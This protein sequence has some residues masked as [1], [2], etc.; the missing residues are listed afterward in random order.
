MTTAITWAEIDPD[1]H[2]AEP[3]EGLHAH[4]DAPNGIVMLFG[5]EDETRF[6]LQF[7][8]RQERFYNSQDFPTRAAAAAAL[9][10]LEG[11]DI[12]T[13]PANLDGGTADR[14]LKWATERAELGRQEEAG[15]RVD[16]AGSDDDAVEIV[17]D[18]ADLINS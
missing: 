14:I 4:T 10:P 3:G 9:A 18:I 12:I 11:A 15:E 7:V 13:T 5:N 16:Y 8:D 6:Y 17:R 1:N 2:F